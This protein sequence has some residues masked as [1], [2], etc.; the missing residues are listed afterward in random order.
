MLPV[1]Y[2]F[3]QQAYRTDCRIKSDTVIPG[4][5]L[6]FLDIVIYKD[7]KQF[8][9]TLKDIETPTNYQRFYSRTLNEN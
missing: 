1:C 7:T 5:S 9:F 4:I 2:V 8:P 3:V 6:K